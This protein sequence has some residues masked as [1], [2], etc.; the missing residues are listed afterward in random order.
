MQDEIIN[1]VSQSGLITID[2]E[3][4]FQEEDCVAFDIKDCLVEGLLLREKHFRELS[5]I[6][7]GRFIKANLLRC[8]VLPMQSFRAGHGC[9]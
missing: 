4:F 6:I 5:K 3:T 2:L 8:I 9:Y 7:I 1:K